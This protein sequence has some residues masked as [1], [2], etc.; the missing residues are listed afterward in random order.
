MKK[1]KIVLHYKKKKI[2]LEVRE[3]NFFERGRGL[4]FRKR[5]NARA[6]L[7]DLNGK[8][9]DCLTS[10]FVFF[11]FLAI[12]LDEKNNILEIKKVKPWTFYV[13]SRTK[14]SKIVEIPINLQYR[15]QIEILVGK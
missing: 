9:K 7:F 8:Y 10:F 2:E 4:T 14:W 1:K 12:W 6:L 3:L 15:K 11:D 5:E 13:N